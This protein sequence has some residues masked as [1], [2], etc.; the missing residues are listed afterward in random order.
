MDRWLISDCLQ[1]MAEHS[2]LCRASGNVWWMG[3]V[4]LPP[5]THFLPQVSTVAIETAGQC[6][7]I[8]YQNLLYA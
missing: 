4:S 1:S 5:T 7:C 2:S 8:L 3:V 6:I